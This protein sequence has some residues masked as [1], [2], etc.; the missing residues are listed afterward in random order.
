MPHKM[1]RLNSENNSKQ[2]DTIKKFNFAFYLQRLVFSKCNGMHSENLQ[3][4]HREAA[5][6][7]LTKN[8]DEIIK[9]R[10]LQRIN[11][12]GSFFLLSSEQ[13]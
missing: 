10:K 7:P 6:V 9:A 2:F 11:I 13:F 8:A 1:S 3:C 12:S 4:S 5:I